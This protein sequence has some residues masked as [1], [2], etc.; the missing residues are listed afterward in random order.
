METQGWLLAESKGGVDE[1]KS[2]QKKGLALAHLA[3]R[4]SGTKGLFLGDGA[5]GSGDMYW[6]PKGEGWDSS[7]F[8][9]A[10]VPVI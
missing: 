6:T 2:P 7:F 3:S 9:S 5:Q 8:T 10:C 4:I 1:T